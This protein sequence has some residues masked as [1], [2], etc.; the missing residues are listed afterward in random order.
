M[1]IISFKFFNDVKKVS[2]RLFNKEHFTD[3]CKNEPDVRKAVV[4]A[5]ESKGAVYCLMNKEK[6]CT[7]LHTFYKIPDP[8][9]R[10]VFRLV[11][12]YSFCADG[13]EDSEN[14]FIEVLKG[15]I[16]ERILFTGVNSVDWD[17]EITTVEDIENHKETFLGM[18]TSMLLMLAI[19]FLFLDMDVVGMVLMFIVFI[20]LCSGAAIKIG[21]KK[22]E[23]VLETENDKADNKPDSPIQ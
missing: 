18:S 12:D 1:E 16:Q 11:K 5:L 8:D 17:G 22:D 19:L 20:S 15:E 23:V 10:K 2:M 9:N 4:K 3:L 21:H 6:Q 13:Y 14:K 7:C